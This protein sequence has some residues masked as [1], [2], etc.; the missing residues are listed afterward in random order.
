MSEVAFIALGSNLGDRHG[1]LLRARTKLAALPGTRIIA[2][3]DVEDTPPLG[4]ADQPS[5][6]NQMIAIETILAPETLMFELQRIENEEGRERSER[7]G[8]RTLDL[9]IVEFGER[10]VS[11]RRLMIPHPELPHRDFWQRQL[12]ALKAS[13]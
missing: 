1:Y 5:Y 8:S 9:D 7:W 2:E 12:A 11:S 6:L 13:L 3:S 10:T 4:N